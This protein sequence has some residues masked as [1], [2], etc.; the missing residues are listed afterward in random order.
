MGA[1]SMAL[2]VI[3]GG[4][5]FAV[6]GPATE[7]AGNAAFISV[8]LA[9]LL[10][11]LTGISYSR[12]TL[13]FNE[14]GG[15]FVYISPLLGTEIAGTLSWFLILAYLFTTALYASTFGAF[16]TLLLDISWQHAPSLGALVI[17]LLA[18]VNL[19]GIRFSSFFENFLIYSNIGLLLFLAGKSLQTISLEEA[20]PVLEVPSK[21]IIFAAAQ[22]FV[23]FEGFQLL[24]YNYHDIDNHK[25]NFPRAMRTAILLSI[26]LYILLAFVTTAAVGNK[27]AG[28]QPQTI[29]ID[30]A[31]LVLEQQGLTLALVIITLSM[32]AAINA[33]MFSHGRLAK[34]L[35]HEH[36]IPPG[37]TRRQYSGVPLLYL[38]FIVAAV[39]GII[40]TIDL[41]ELAAFSSLV[42]LSTFV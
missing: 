16:A 31:G 32:T 42:L 35:A 3:I 19:A 33:T 5:F 17:I 8:G 36:E 12:L 29:L 14:P 6:L 34:R 38:V 28:E 40:F 2:G 10:A 41:D 11:L 1:T 26:A 39:I 9:G 30:L 15:S 7:T 24:T 37:L 27:V 4:G 23:G 13:R 20:L 25:K 21:E 18:V 22:M